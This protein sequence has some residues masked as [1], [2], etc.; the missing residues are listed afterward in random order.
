VLETATHFVVRLAARRMVLSAVR[1]GR[2]EG[3]VRAPREDL[4]RVVFNLLRNATDAMA[5][6]KHGTL[7]LSTWATEE[8]AFVRVSDDG[9]GILQSDLPHM[10]ELLFTTRRDGTGL[11]LYLC[12]QLVERWGGRIQVESRPGEGARFTFSVPREQAR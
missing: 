3:Y 7:V 12:K 11:G 2:V 1:E 5:E 10:F 9:P 6:R 4:L 8:T